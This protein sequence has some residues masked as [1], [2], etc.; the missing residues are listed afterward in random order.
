[1]N[2]PNNPN[3]Q[4]TNSHKGDTMNDNNTQPRALWTRTDGSTTE[5]P[6][7]EMMRAYAAAGFAGTLQPIEPQVAADTVPRAVRRASVG[8]FAGRCRR[9]RR[10]LE[11]R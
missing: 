11:R 10:Y 9:A 4:P 7:D 2:T 1:M 3:N 5:G 8:G 6:A